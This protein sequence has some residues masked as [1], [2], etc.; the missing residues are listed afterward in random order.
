M[1]IYLF[2]FFIYLFIYFFFFVLFCFLFFFFFFFFFFDGVGGG[3]GGGWGGG[4]EMGNNSLLSRLRQIWQF[5]KI[6]RHYKSYFKQGY[7][8]TKLTHSVYSCTPP[9]SQYITEEQ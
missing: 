6:D 8:T 2:F 5:E 9:F 7:K 1:F 3:G 4:G